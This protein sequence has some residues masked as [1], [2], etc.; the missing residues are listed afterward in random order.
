MIVVVERGYRGD[1]EVTAINPGKSIILTLESAER[2]FMPW[3]GL[4]GRTDDEKLERGLKL[5]LGTS[6][7]VEV[8][9]VYPGRD[10]SRQI[11]VR[12]V[13]RTRN[14]N[15]RPARTRP[16]HNNRQDKSGGVTTTTRDGFK[17]WRAK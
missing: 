9:E 3:N 11:R 15:A 14:H 5:D 8:M 2:C 1:A 6:M 16:R 4:A 7:F 12:E 10:F 17:V 13:D